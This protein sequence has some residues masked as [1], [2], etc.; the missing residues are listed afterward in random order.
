MMPVKALLRFVL[1]CAT[2]FSASSVG[3][4]D[5]IDGSSTVNSPTIDL[6][7]LYAFTAGAEQESLVVILNIITATQP[8]E[9]PHPSAIFEIVFSAFKPIERETRFELLDAPRYRLSCRWVTD[10]AICEAPDGTQVHARLDDVPPPGP[11]RIFAGSRSDPFVL[12]GLWA[13]KLAISNAIPQPF[14]LNIINGLNVFSIVAE[15][16]IAQLMPDLAGQAIAIGADVR[17]VASGRILD[18]VGRPEIANIALQSNEGDDL[19]DAMNAFPA[20]IFPEQFR[21]TIWARLRENLDRYD[22]MDP[23]PYAV[24][25]DALAEILADDYLTIDPSL[26]CEGARYFDLEAAALERTS[27]TRCGGRPLAQDIIDSVYGLMIRGNAR[28]GIAD[29]VSQPTRA[30]LAD[31][32]Y[33]AEPNSG[34]RG[35]VLALIGR[36]IADISVPGPS[37]T[38]M[39]L[40][41]GGIVIALLALMVLFARWIWRR[42]IKRTKIG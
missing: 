15:I 39:L 1:A 35:V 14:D 32:P 9:Y 26:P 28:D 37:R 18:R 24:N 42:G 3:A 8:W 27:A 30:A 12:N 34:F 16:N 31:F 23:A 38:H 6:T 22:A 33:L 5:H 25:K 41:V 11:I 2:C 4:T 21:G 40:V 19:R 13:S 36:A 17:D 20:L 7:D 29:G 10:G